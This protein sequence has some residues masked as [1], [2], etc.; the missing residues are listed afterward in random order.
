M[1]AGQ[2]HGLG[3]KAWLG[4]GLWG[5][6]WG[7]AKWQWGLSEQGWGEDGAKTQARA[8]MSVLLGVQQDKIS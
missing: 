1:V 4:S 5:T 2:V 8:N 7:V 3:R 6:E